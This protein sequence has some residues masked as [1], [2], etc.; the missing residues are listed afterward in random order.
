MKLMRLIAIGAMALSAVMPFAAP[1]SAA[2]DENGCIEKEYGAP[3]FCQS[4]TIRYENAVTKIY[5][6]TDIFGGHWT[7]V[8]THL[9]ASCTP[10]G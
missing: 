8:V 4:C 1:A 10:A 9:G 7:C 3:P 5:Y 6:C 2:G